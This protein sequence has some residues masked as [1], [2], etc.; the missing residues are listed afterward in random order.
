MASTLIKSNNPRKRM[1]SHHP[2]TRRTARR[3]SHPD[4]K[5]AMRQKMITINTFKKLRKESFSKL[6]H[7][8]QPDPNHKRD[9]LWS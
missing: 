1:R 2:L 8:D 3:I 6:N 9:L 7:R 4:N 5:M